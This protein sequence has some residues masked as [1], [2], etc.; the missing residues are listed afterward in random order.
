VNDGRVRSKSHR[1][2]LRHTGVDDAVE[3][4]RERSWRETGSRSSISSQCKNL[5]NVV[6]EEV[7]SVSGEVVVDGETTL[8]VE[9]LCRCSLQ[10]TS[11]YQRLEMN[12]NIGGGDSGDTRWYCTKTAKHRITQT[13]PYDNT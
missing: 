1:A 5:Q 11:P 6:G 2:R 3:E 7:T 8:Q 13:T 12:R 9:R 4:K 10:K